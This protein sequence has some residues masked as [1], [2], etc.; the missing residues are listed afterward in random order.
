MVELPA[1]GNLRSRIP[2]QWACGAAGS[3][4][5][6]HGRGRRFDPDQVHHF[7]HPICPPQ[8]APICTSTRNLQALAVKGCQFSR[9]TNHL[10]N[11]RGA[12]QRPYSAPSESSPA[13]NIIV[14]KR[15]ACY[16]YLIVPHGRPIV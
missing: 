5:P 10:N 7:Q 15:P 14:Q 11:L 3:A 6:W 13:K 4:L 9:S 2:K 12:A 16:Y 8:N 1:T